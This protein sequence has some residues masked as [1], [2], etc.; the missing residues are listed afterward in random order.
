MKINESVTSISEIAMTFNG[1]T[2]SSNDTTH[3]IYVLK[4]DQD[5]TQNSSWVQVGSDQVIP[6]GVDTTIT[7][8]VTNNIADYV[9]PN[10]EIT[11]GVYS[12]RSSETLR[13]NYV[14]MQVTTN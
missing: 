8:T 10:G 3:R 2:G 14:E 11:W 6:G 7:G 1:N 13:T 12:T 9:G 4:A 5:W